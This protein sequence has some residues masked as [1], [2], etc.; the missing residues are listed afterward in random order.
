MASN[1][2]WDM[3]TPTM[4][5]SKQVLLRMAGGAEMTEGASAF[6]QKRTPDFRQF[7]K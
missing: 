1:V 6:M 7:R 2:W 3:T 5:L 4:E